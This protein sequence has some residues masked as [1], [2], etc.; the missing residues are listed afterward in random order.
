MKHAKKLASL[1]LALVMMFALT[2]TAFADETTYTIT[3]PE[4]GHTYELYQIF[5]GDLYDGVLSNVKWGK[6]GTG[7]KGEAVS[8]TILSELEATNGTDTEKLAVITKYVDL[9]SA[10]YNTVVGGTPLTGV[11]A[12]YYLIKDVDGAL[13]GKDDSYTTY[14]VEVVQNVNINPKSDVSEVV[15]KV[16]DTNDS[17]GE[18]SDWQD[19]ADYD[20]GDSVPF[21]LTATLADNVSA[22]YS[23]KVVFHDTLSAGLTYNND[24]KV[25]FGANDV[26][27]HF[28]IN[29]ENGVLTISCDNVKEFGATDS[30]VIIVEY[31]ATLNENA[32]I[33]SAG[34]PNTVKLDYSNNPNWKPGEGEGPEDSPKGTTPEDTVIVFTF[35]TVVNKV[36]ENPDYDPDVEGSEKFIPLKGAGFTLYKKN[37]SGVYEAVGS[38][39]KGNDMTT[40]TWS[41]LDD[42]DY[43]LVE[44]TT[45]AGYNTI[46]DIEFTITAEHQ[47]LS[48][49]PTLISLGGG[50]KF[51]GEVSTGA[52][53]ADIEN[54]AGT[55]L[56]ETGGIGTTIF[57]IL[58]SVLL[59]GA[60]VLLITKKRMSAEK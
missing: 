50:D 34:N 48:D 25:T 19:S 47:V 8:E 30:S 42:G 20:I 51:T 38:E 13:A 41:G 18:T 57:Y 5:T 9:T 21:Q 56:P 17:T 58:G 23:Y 7:T 1:L 43:K 59:V 3:A 22:Y 40:F 4:N 11:P 36:T 32:V 6:N 33:G 53:S 46:A 37:A 39:L 16:K 31:T 49:N 45:P 60:A 2:T 14:I 28:E 52:V 12:G 55:T 44:T 24:A 29:E 26:T 15:K 54:K 35:K 27:S 10:P